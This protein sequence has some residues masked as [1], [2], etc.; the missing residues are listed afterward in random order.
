MVRSNGKTKSDYAAA[1]KQRRD[2]DRQEK[3]E[4]KP[5]TDAE[6]EKYKKEYERFHQEYLEEKKERE[7]RAALTQ[8]ERNAE[9]GVKPPRC[10][11]C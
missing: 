8:E 4:V 10:V 7:R 3:W 11:L 6:K 1:R 5:M 9:D 2:F